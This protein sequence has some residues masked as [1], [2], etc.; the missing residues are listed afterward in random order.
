MEGNSLNEPM[1][2]RTQ[3][4]IHE[5]ETKSKTTNNQTCGSRNTFPC[6]SD[7]C[8]EFSLDSPDVDLFFHFLR[9]LDV[10]TG[11]CTN[12]SQFHSPSTPLG[13]ARLSSA[14]PRSVRMGSG[15]ALVRLGPA[16]LGPQP[17]SHPF[18]PP[19][20]PHPKTCPKQSPPSSLPKVYF[21]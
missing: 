5:D 2:N 11:I 9:S 17:P 19:N 12:M 1:F 21:L 6:H 3:T 15:S 18:H 8:F 4:K 16:W 20:H 7:R 14:R 10:A 13:S